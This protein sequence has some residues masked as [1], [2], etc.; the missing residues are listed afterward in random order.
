MRILIALMISASVSFA[1]AED[2]TSV[3]QAKIDATSAAGGGKVTVPAGEYEIAGL[4]L[5]DGVELHLE[6]DAK[7][8]AVT[9]LEAYAHMKKTGAHA[10]VV[11]A[12]G[13]KNIAITGEGVID[14]RGK[15]FNRVITRT[16]RLKLISGWKDVFLM[17]CCEVR[18][19]GVTMLGATS[20]TCYLNGCDGV[21]VKRVKMFSHAN[22]NNDGLDIQSSNVIVEDCDI[23]SEDDSI[24]IKANQPDADVRNVRVR[25]CRLST[26]SSFIKFG[27]E[28]KGSFKDVVIENCELECR[29]PIYARSTHLNVPGVKDTKNGISGIE[30]SMV[31]GGR[32]EDVTIR[33]IRMG[34]GVNTPM[35]VRLGARNEPADGG[36]TYLRNVLIENVRMTKPATSFQACP[37][38][39]LPNLPVENITFRNIELLFQGGGKLTDARTLYRNE[40]ASAFPSPPNVFKHILPGYAFYVRHAKNVVFD[41]VKTRV[42]GSELCPAVVTECAEVDFRNC[43]FAKAKDCSEEN[44]IVNRP[45]K[46]QYLIIAGDST[47]AYRSAT[48]KQGSWGEAVRGELRDDFE[49]MNFAIGGRSTKTFM[50]EWNTNVVKRINS[51]D[52]VLIQ[53][54][55]NDMSKASDPKVDRQTDPDTEYKRNLRKYIADVR[56]RKAQ[57]LLVTSITLYLYNRNPNEW[58]ANNPLAPWVKAMLEVAE[59]TKTPVVDMNALTVKAV[60]GAGAEESAKWYMFSEN[61]KDWAHPTKLGAG[62]FADLF[63]KEVRSRA[64][65]TGKFLKSNQ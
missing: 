33:D 5:K 3:W 62:I 9:N 36:N 4:Q 6:K 46:K 15:F 40:R 20:W 57:P 43:E 47:Q 44:S 22:F 10:S 52:W 32:L 13:A 48:A 37:V 23:D 30:V 42:L 8:L 1:S 64:D 29:T 14:G 54:G 35:M 24:V 27:T 49:L 31:D 34:D 41:N 38:A 58:S 26:N 65:L 59:E 53:F 16:P 19:D 12:V 60:T 56:A 39:G 55:H 21:A 51:G 18:I 63:L 17:Q 61:G 25:N 2:V 11:F 28:T 50:E 45:F 7:L